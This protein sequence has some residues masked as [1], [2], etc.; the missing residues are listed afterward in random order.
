MYNQPKECI[1]RR[2]TTQTYHTFALIDSPHRGILMTL[3][4]D[5][6]AEPTCRNISLVSIVTQ[7]PQ[8]QKALGFESQLMFGTEMAGCQ[9]DLLTP[10]CSYQL[11]F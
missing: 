3:V 7:I 9:R 11:F 2:K 5:L 10:C 4:I 8:C 1:F 6:L